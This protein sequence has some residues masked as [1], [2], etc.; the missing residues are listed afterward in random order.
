[1]ISVDQ[2][3]KQLIEL[4]L[5]AGI[6]EYFGLIKTTQSPNGLHIFYRRNH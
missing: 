5:P 1:M 6:L 2:N 4:L 3:Y